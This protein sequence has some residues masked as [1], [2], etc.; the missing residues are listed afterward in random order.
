MILAPLHVGNSRWR[1]LA[2]IL[3]A[4]DHNCRPSHISVAFIHRYRSDEVVVSGRNVF[5]TLLD[6][7]FLFH[8]LTQV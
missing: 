8:L 2:D 6:N 7:P 3:T 4:I 1:N 5:R